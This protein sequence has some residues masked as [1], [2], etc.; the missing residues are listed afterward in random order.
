MFDIRISLHV[1]WCDQPLDR[2]DRHI[3]T[4]LAGSLSKERER[5]TSSRRPGRRLPQLV[6]LPAGQEVH[7]FYT[8]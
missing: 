4:V 3:A 5:A 8:A 1:V 7:R 2:T 6:K